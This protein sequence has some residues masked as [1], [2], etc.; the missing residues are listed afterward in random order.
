MLHMGV[1]IHRVVKLKYETGYF[2][3]P[4]QHDF[5]HYA[6]VVEGRGL[7]R[8][9]EEELEVNKGEMFLVPIRTRHEIYSIDNLTNIN[10]KFTTHPALEAKLNR[11]ACHIKTLSLHEEN[12]VRSILDEA[13]FFDEFSE[14]MINTRFTELLLNLLRRRPAQSSAG[15]AERRIVSE[16]AAAPDQTCEELT[17]V[18]DY[19][20]RHIDQP[21]NVN[22]L[23]EMSG[24]SDSYFCTLFRRS[25]G[26]TPIQ[27]INY[28]K[29]DRS[30]KLMACTDYNVTK[31]AEMLGFDNVHY[32]S[33][34]FKQKIGIA[35]NE[36]MKKMKGDIVV[37]VIRDSI[38]IPKTR[39]E[40]MHVLRKDTGA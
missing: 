8:I 26:Q 22:V 23:A 37:N 30:I 29:I 2:I 5:F 31:I 6:Y 11:L 35:P 9:G 32:F 36:Y 21:L 17:P 10:I 39:Y 40:N 7:V 13:V 20:L 1:E 3:E 12:I 38:L 14:E 33:R 24:Y 16:F 18:I 25:F 27:Y 28:L 15:V 34:L 4:H 19:I